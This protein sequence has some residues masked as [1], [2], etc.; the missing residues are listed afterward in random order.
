MRVVPSPAVRVSGLWENGTQTTD[1]LTCRS[2]QQTRCPRDNRARGERKPTIM[3][4]IEALVLGIVQ[5]ITEFLPISS[6]AHL[7]IIPALLKGADSHHSWNDPGAAASAIIQLGT[8]LA[9][10]V[11]FRSDVASLTR[12][13]VQSLVTGR[14][15]RTPESRLAWYIGGATVPLVGAGWLFQDFIK[16]QARSLWI[17]AGSLIVLALLLWWAERA[18]RHQRALSELRFLDAQIIGVAQ[19]LAL[20][21]GSS[22]SG[23][24]ITA[25]L[26]LGF[27]REAAARFSF[28]LSIPAV[29]LSGLW[30][31]YDIRHELTAATSGGLVVATI[32]AAVSGYAAIAFLLRYLRTHTMYLF[33]VYRLALG[34]LLIILLREGRIR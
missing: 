32:A 34:L 18:S 25:G 15:L 16:T 27:T 22:R 11:Y 30:E 19:A 8:L 24:T 28:L 2:E 14:P 26:F 13:L 33:V 29:A 31:L 21:P 10:L 3:S 20:V 1:Y 12:A 4:L 9:V 6:T 17:I 23:T 7:R 5:G